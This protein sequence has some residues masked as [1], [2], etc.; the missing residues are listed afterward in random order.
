[1]Y[2]IGIDLVLLSGVVVKLWLLRESHLDVKAL[3][4]AE[5]VNG[6]RSEI[7]VEQ[8]N[9]WGKLFVIGILLLLTGWYTLAV[10]EP[11]VPEVARALVISEA[12]FAAIVVALVGPG[13]YAL[14]QRRKQMKQYREKQAVGWD[15]QDRRINKEKQP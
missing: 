9:A 12:I 5:M 10:P 13:V 1:V 8:V 15:G 11:R 4:R 14:A 7:R 3:T 2:E 6:K